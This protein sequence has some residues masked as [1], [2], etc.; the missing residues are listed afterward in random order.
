[1]AVVLTAVVV[2]NAGQNHAEISQVLQDFG[3][4]TLLMLVSDDDI[5]G[6]IA[7]MPEN[8]DLIIFD[9][10]ALDDPALR[11]DVRQS[12]SERGVPLIFFLGEGAI[13]RLLSKSECSI[14]NCH[15]LSRP[16]HELSLRIKLSEV[17]GE[18]RSSDSSADRH[19]RD[20]FRT[21]NDAILIHNADGRIIEANPQGGA[22][23]RGERGQSG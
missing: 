5:P 16:M 15:I 17:R 3:Y 9:M 23:P 22:A 1:M 12:L 13:L 4:R 19:Y 14:P 10:E 20:L 21:H 18:G 8:V 11:N 6:G 2:T 7:G